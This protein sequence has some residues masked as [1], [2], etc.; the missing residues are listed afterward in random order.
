MQDRDTEED[1]ADLVDQETRGA[2]G[3]D[4][5]EAGGLE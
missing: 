5:R 3:L 2:G 4:S 1:Q